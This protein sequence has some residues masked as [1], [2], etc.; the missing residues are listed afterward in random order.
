M[1]RKMVVLVIT[2]ALSALLLVA[3]SPAGAITKPTTI[4]LRGVA[5]GPPTIVDHGNDGVI[6]PGDYTFLT[7]QLINEKK[8]FGKKKGAKVG[9]AYVAIFNF[10]PGL[11]LGLSAATLP[12]GQIVSSGIAD[13]TKKFTIGVTG[14]TRTYGNAQGSMTLTPVSP[15]EFRIVMKLTPG[16]K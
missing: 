9:F 15:T 1:Y 6:A 3:A 13:P 2:G 7:L 12:K 5:A 10:A 4:K 11:D 14:G 16:G 8:Q